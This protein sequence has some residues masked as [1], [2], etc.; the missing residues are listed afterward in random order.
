MG[1]WSETGA[2]M[3]NPLVD[4]WVGFLESL[5]GIF[6]ALVLII[7]GWAVSR[8]MGRLLEKVLVRVKLDKHIK[9]AGLTD[10]IGHLE[11]SH[12]SGEILKWYIFVVFLG[13]AVTLLKLGTLTVLLGSFLFWV[14]NVLIALVIII[15]G[16]LFADFAAAK[17]DKTKIRSIRFVSW[18]VKAGI[19]FF[20]V[21]MAFK[22]LNLYVSIAEATFLIVL[23]GVSLALALAVGIGFG[24]AL[25]DEAKDLIKGFKRKL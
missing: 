2:S 19:M 8:L 7:I 4:V 5:P 14:P 1:L 18:L 15:V 21:I 23:G 24:L 17:L 13:E 12:I 11:L 22:Q 9:K 3:M 16:L 25:K 20:A 6:W 10:S